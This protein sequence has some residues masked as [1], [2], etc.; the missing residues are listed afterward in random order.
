M[1]PQGTLGR[2]GMGSPT[3]EEKVCCPEK[4]WEW[5]PLASVTGTLRHCVQLKHPSWTGQV[6]YCGL[7]L[8]FNLN[9]ILEVS[10]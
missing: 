8:I 4:F 10:C 2:K 5:G 6:G 9:P 3:A 7:V 1:S